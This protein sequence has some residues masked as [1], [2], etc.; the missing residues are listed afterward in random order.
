MGFAKKSRKAA[1]ARE[2]QAFDDM[3]A[4]TQT[5]EKARQDYMNQFAERNK[6]MIGMQESA[7]GRIR[8][9]ETGQDIGQRMAGMHSALR[10]GAQGVMNAQRLT[11]G[12]GTN[13]LAQ[14]DPRYAM[15]L[16]SIANRNIASQIGGAL[17]EQSANMYQQDIG[18]AMGASQ[19]L[20]ADRLAGVSGLNEAVQNY[21]NLGNFAS[22]IR[23]TEIARSQAIFNNIMG[24]ANFAMGAVTGF[25]G[26]GGGKG[27]AK[28]GSSATKASFGSSI[29]QNAPSLRQGSLGVAHDHGRF[30]APR[31]GDYK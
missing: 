6:G 3:R 26:M 15:K 17:A 24:V 14:Q 25:A 8:G 12:M 23:Q 16:Q 30:R 28:G 11:S 31:I 20:N 4:S 21:G 29:G 10:A 1:Q 2:K 19:F 9:F 5:A 13:A 27:A 18:T 22:R 7:F